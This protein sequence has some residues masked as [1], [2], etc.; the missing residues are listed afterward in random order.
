VVFRT[1]SLLK[2]QPLLRVEDEDGEGPVQRALD[3]RL[4]LLLDPEFTVLRVNED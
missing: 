1:R 2:Q 4:H 3:V